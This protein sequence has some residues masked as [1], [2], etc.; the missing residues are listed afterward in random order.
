MS[1]LFLTLFSRFLK[2]QSGGDTN[3]FHHEFEIGDLLTSCAVKV[4]VIQL[5]REVAEVVSGRGIPWARSPWFG[6]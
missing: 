1:M 4:E 6:S 2:G 5:V 3:L